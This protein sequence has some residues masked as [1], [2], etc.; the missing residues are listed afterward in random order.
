VSTVLAYEC[1]QEPCTQ[2]I[3]SQPE[4][5]GEE[6]AEQS[7][8]FERNDGPPVVGADHV[9]MRIYGHMAKSGMGRLLKLGWIC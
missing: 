3:L 1:T 5:T 8:L 2:D 4:L 6:I 9:E 7:R